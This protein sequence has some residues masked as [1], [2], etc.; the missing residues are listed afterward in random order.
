MSI[1]ANALRDVVALSCVLSRY[2]GSIAWMVRR[3]LRR[4]HALAQAIPNPVLRRMA[5]DKLRREYL[6][7]HAAAVFAAPAPRRRRRDLVRLLVT[8]Q[9]MYDYLDGVSELPAT[10]PVAHGLCLYE[11]LYAVIGEPPAGVDYYRWH[12]EGVDGGYLDDLAAICRRCL[13]RLPSRGVVL[14]VLERAI[15]RCGEAQTRAHAVAACGREQL[16]DWAEPLRA[17]AAGLHWWELAAGAASS[18]LLHAI[19]AAAAEPAITPREASAV[20]AA[21]FPASALSALLDSLIDHHEDRATGAHR[22]IGYYA[23]PDAVGERLAAIAHDGA[24]RVAGL[25]RG[26]VHVVIATG[27]AGFYLSGARGTFAESTGQRV[28]AALNPGL[29]RPIL[30]L[31][32]IKRRR[33]ERHDGE[34]RA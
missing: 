33:A 19:L 26:R 22:F 21:Y 28:I 31:A 8:F 24:A 20:E 16:R 23:S 4:C 32:R 9:V 15:P 12:P 3:E 13:D 29:L 18:V 30:A 5:L 27:V 1:S 17:L 14:P 25:R 11:A 34:S 6:H 7:A 2:Y 10:D